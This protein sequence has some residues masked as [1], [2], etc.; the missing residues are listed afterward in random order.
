MGL[1]VGA[2]RVEATLFG[3]GERTGNVD[4]VTLA[5][6]MYTQGVDPQLDFS[7]IN[8]IREMFERC[9]KM[10]VGDRQPLRRQAG[11][12]RLL[13]QPSGR[14]QQGH[15]VYEGVQLRFLG[16]PLSAHRPRR[17]GPGV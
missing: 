17:R 2:D 13:R 8:K 4:I 15:P 7:N 10:P 3:N 14:H 1:L 5:M 12:H 16:D 9:T 11:V 6:N